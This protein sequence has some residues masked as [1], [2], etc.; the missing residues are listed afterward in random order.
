M[1][2]IEDGEE[3]IVVGTIY[4]EMALKP[5]VLEEY[6][7]EIAL[8]ARA[9][10]KTVILEDYTADDDHLILEDESGM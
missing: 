7:N 10:I 9:D 6:E 8:D 3:V 1:I 4:K 2:N 5:N